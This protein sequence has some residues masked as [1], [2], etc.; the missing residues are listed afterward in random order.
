MYIAATTGLILI[1]IISLYIRL[2]SNGLDAE[3]AE[4]A[5][6]V[7]RAIKRDASGGSR[8]HRCMLRE[9]LQDDVGDEQPD[10]SRS[11]DGQTW[12]EFPAAELIFWYLY[13]NSANVH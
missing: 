8:C 10:T 11:P 1:I 6:V 7:R 2:P 4:I 13:K 3:L 12:V 9:L 5:V